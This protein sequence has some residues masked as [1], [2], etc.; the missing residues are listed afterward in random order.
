MTVIDASAIVL[1]LMHDGDARQVLAGD[2]PGRAL[3][4]WA[5]LGAHREASTWLSG[6]V[7]QLR[8]NL[9]AYDACYVAPAETLDRA[10]A[11]A[12][13]RLA[14]APGSRCPFRLPKS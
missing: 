9:S 6:R 4:R 2:E 1:G 14:G 3:A 5:Q 12:D 7:R 11:T 10:L 8:D 13:A